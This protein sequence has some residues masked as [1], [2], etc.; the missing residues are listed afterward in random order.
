[1]QFPSPRPL[2]NPRAR[3]GA[4]AV[5]LILLLS[6][7]LAPGATYAKKKYKE[8]PMKGQAGHIFVNDTGETVHGL[9]VQLNQKAEVVEDPATNQA[10]PFLNVSG[11]G[12]QKIVLSNPTALIETGSEGFSLVFR[13]YKD[14]LKIAKYW[15]QD[16]K[17]K[18]VGEKKKP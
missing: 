14:G 8:P 18:Q 13:S 17:G 1:M 3:S 12:S 7:L 4:L 16:E 10:G 5:I 2:A 6:T 15:W 9:I 11:N